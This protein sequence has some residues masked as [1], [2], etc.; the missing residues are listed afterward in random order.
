MNTEKRTRAPLQL[1]LIAAVFFGPLIFAALL[2]FKGDLIQ[3][4]ARTNHGALLEPI[5]SIRDALPESAAL[6]HNR[7]HWLLVYSDLNPCGDPCRDALYTIRQMRL[8]LG[9]EMDRVRRLF[10][11]GD[12]PLDT[13]FIAEEHQG[14]ITL[15]DEELSSLLSNKKPADLPAGGYY[16]IDPLGNVVLYFS[17]DIEPVDIVEDMKRLLKLSHIG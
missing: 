13:L 11:H 12:A 2:Y 5:V 1:A 16:L 15:R 9:K 3:P 14:L 17:P 4:E 10:L 6:E 7:E 8:M